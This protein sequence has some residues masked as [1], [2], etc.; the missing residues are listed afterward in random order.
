MMLLNNPTFLPR[1]TRRKTTIFG[2]ISF[3]TALG[4]LAAN[5]GLTGLLVHIS[6]HNYPG[7]EAIAAFHQLVP[8]TTLRKLIFVSL[9]PHSHSITIIIAPP[10]VHICNLAA[11]SGTT[12]FQ[13]LNSPPYHSALYLW[14][15]SVPPTTPWIYN[16]TE[17]LTLSELSRSSHFTHIISEQPPTSP[18]IAGHWNLMKAIPAFDRVVLDKELLTHKRWELPRRIF[19]LIRI[20]EKDQLW[21][22]ERK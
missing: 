20:V 6:M 22:Y 3:I 17:N 14:P 10:H 1:F 13:H 7:G 8:A 4:F 2:P 21:I 12:L 19:D 15:N 16:K 18:E 11:Q 9:I 5:F